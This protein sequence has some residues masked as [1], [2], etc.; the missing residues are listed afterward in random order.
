MQETAF[1]TTTRLSRLLCSEN[2]NS[3]RQNVKETMRN[4][5][6]WAAF[7]LL[8]FAVEAQK[9]RPALSAEKRMVKA[10]IAVK[11]L[12]TKVYGTVAELWLLDVYKGEDK[13]AAALGLPGKGPDAVFHLKDQ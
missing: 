10:S 2:T 1:R 13:L 11:A 9:C 6:L 5:L 7:L 4:K 12:V 3:A 8:F